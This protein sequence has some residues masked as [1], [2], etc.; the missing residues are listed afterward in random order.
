MLADVP[1]LT[2][3]LTHHV[4]H[5]FVHHVVNGRKLQANI[6]PGNAVASLQGSS[7]T[8]GTGLRITTITDWRARTAGIAA[9]DVSAS[10]G[11]IHVIDRVILPLPAASSALAAPQL[12]ILIEAVQAA[13]LVGAL[14][15][16]GPLPAFKPTND[17]F[18]ALLDELSVSK[19]ALLADVRLLTRVLTYHVLNG[20]VLRARVP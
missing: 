14:S 1:L 9:T 3:V 2:R 6:P 5:H 20:H 12:S 19:E 11:V 10:N 4:V 13:R 17:A 16:S 8:A 18:A 7:F 15:A